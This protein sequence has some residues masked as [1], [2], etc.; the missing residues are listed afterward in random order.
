MTKHARVLT[1]VEHLGLVPVGWIF[2]YQDDQLS[3]K[4]N[5]DECEEPQGMDFATGA[6][7]QIEKM[8]KHG[9]YVGNRFVTLPMDVTTGATES[10]QP[11]DATIQM[12]HKDMFESLVPPPQ[13]LIEKNNPRTITTQHAV[14]VDG[15]ETTKLE[16]VLVCLIN[17]DMLSHVGNYA[18]K[19]LASSVKKSNGDLTIKAKKVLL[20]SALE[21]ND[22]TLMEV[23]MALDQSLSESEIERLCKCVKKWESGHGVKKKAQVWTPS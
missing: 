4:C 22:R 1:I 11:S 3:E 18:G 15:Q 7:L 20:L 16:S 10:F 5:S 21:N 14:L 12:V 23:L 2:S 19:T 17:F 6:V 8:K 9:R 13:T